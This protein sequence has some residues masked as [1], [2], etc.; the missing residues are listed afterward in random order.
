MEQK[1]D[2]PTLVDTKNIKQLLLYNKKKLL[3][4]WFIVK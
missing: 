4:S 3:N 1:S 2:L